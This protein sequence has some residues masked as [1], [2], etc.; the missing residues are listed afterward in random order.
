MKTTSVTINPRLLNLTSSTVDPNPEDDSVVSND[1]STGMGALI[2][3]L[4]F[5]LGVPGNFF[6]VWSILARIRRRSVTCILILNLALAD[7]FLMILTIFF[8]IYL[9]KQTWV[10]G[11]AMCKGLFYLCNTNMYASIFLIT[12]MS[13]QRLVAV[14]FPRKLSSIASRKIVRRV[15]IGMWILVGLIAIPSLVFRDVREDT[16]ERNRIRLVCAPNHTLPRHVSP[17]KQVLV[18]WFSTFFH[19]VVLYNCII[20]TIS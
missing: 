17:Q 3:G 6:I 10:F 7:G 9:A 15:I 12:L 16:D 11:N 1:F 5:L 8:I 20:I 13:L 2:L 19:S 4:V 18:K 14:V